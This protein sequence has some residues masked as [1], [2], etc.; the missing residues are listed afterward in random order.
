M[1]F[2]YIFLKIV[3]LKPVEQLFYFIFKFAYYLI[4]IFTTFVRGGIICKVGTE[5]HSDRNK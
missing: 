3:T 5:L 4:I 1:T 2:R